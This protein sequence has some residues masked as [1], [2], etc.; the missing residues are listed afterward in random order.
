MYRVRS[1]KSVNGPHIPRFKE[2]SPCPKTHALLTADTMISAVFPDSLT[3]FTALNT[4]DPSRA[5]LFPETRIFCLNCKDV[6]VLHK[7]VSIDR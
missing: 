1:R 6:G 5:L 7:G 3:C 4:L 2:D